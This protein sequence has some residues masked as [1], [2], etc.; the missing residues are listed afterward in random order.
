M[1]KDTHRESDAREPH[2]TG[3]ASPGEKVLKCEDIQQVLLAYMSR[4]LGDTQSVLVREHIRKC[5]VCRAEAVEIEAM[6]AVLRRGS[7]DMGGEDARLT[8][9]RRKRILRAVFHPVIDWMDIHHRFVS[10]LLALLVLAAALVALRNFEIFRREPLEDGI[11]IWRMF[12][13]GKLPELVEQ[14]RQRSTAETGKQTLLRRD[15]YEGQKAD[16]ASEP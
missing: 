10:I 14:E 4:E 13:S 8:D 3:G 2:S 15:G 1:K 12:K 16:M 7:P 5:N 9:E 11:P 6:L